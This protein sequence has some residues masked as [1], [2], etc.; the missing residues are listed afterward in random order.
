MGSIYIYLEALSD[1]LWVKAIRRGLILLI[2]LILAGSLALVLNNLP[3]AAYQSFMIQIFGVNWKIAGEYINNL[4]FG[5]IGLA[6]TG[7]VCFNA[8]E[9]FNAI[10][11]SRIDSYQVA[12]C[13][14]ISFFI[15]TN[16]GTAGLLS[17]QVGN[18]SIFIAILVAIATTELFVRLHY[19]AGRWFKPELADAEPSLNKALTAII[20]F[21]F[22]IIIFTCLRIILINL[23]IDN[24]NEFLSNILE[25][26]FLKIKQPLVSILL[27]LLV[28]QFLWF[29]GIHGSK[30]LF[31]VND[32][33]YLEASKVNA[34]IHSVGGT[35]DHIVTKSFLDAFIIIGGSGATIALIC[36]ILISSQKGSS[37]VIAKYSLLPS[38]FNIN[39]LIVFGLPVVLNPFFIVPFIA[40]PIILALVSYYATHIGFLPVTI[41]DVI[42]TTPPLLSGYLATGSYKGVLMQMFNIGLGI[43][44]YLPFVKLFDNYRLEARRNSFKLM[45][46]TVLTDSCKADKQHLERNDVVGY[47]A[48]AFVADIKKALECDEFYLKYQP[49]VNKQGFITGFEALL[50]WNHHLYGEIP[51]C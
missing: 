11:G 2:P 15:L 38:L 18:N 43:L 42:W 19:R 24:I 17:N 44:I 39:E 37:R 3:V 50:R 8:I 5:I 14:I 25:N 12:L 29:F 40:V 4:T 46:A 47:L 30:L 49:Q 34:Y 26:I 6:L 16:E 13:S 27:Y 45:V 23:G 20:P 33:I 32:N 35:P 9:E 31:A 21:L 1:S 36:A 41:A 48:R 51:H 10:K 22:I 7:T 28:T